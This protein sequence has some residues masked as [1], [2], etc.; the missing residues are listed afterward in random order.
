MVDIGADN[1]DGLTTPHA[2]GKFQIVRELGRGAMGIVYEAF[3]EDLQRRVALKIIAPSVLSSDAQASRRFADEARMAAGVHHP[4]IVTVHETGVVAGTAFLAMEFIEGGSLAASSGE[5]MPAH[6]AARIVLDVSRAVAAMHVRGV[7]HR[8]LKPDNIL[9]DSDGHPRVTDFGLAL[10]RSDQGHEAAGTPGFMA[11]E[12]LSSEFGPVSE[13]SDIY[14][15]GAVLHLLVAGVLPHE[16][17]TVIQLAMATIERDLPAALPNMPAELSAICRRCLERVQAHRYAS[18]TA[19]ADDL[20][21]WLR[22]DAT[23]ATP[24]GSWRRIRSFFRQRRVLAARLVA[25][26]IFEALTIVNYMFLGTPAAYFYDIQILLASLLLASAVLDWANRSG[27]RPRA[28]SYIWPLLDCAGIT[29]LL[30][31]GDGPSSSLTLLYPLLIVS[32]GLWFE[33]SAVVAAT[34]MAA[35]AYGILIAGSSLDVG[36]TTTVQHFTMFTTLLVTGLLVWLQVFRAQA[37]RDFASRSSG[38]RS[39]RP[40]LGRDPASGLD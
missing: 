5:R 21:C 36:V 38:F 13:K 3:Q 32:T 24:P 31:V 10:I 19:L 17:A 12:Q 40:Q 7:V 6:E 8:D 4:G 25:L 35:L 22:G 34:A 20:E 27:L 18:A 30:S 15:L 1:A 2:I 37:L 23:D 14:S 16:S 11:P 9:I 28:M 29:W 33:H 26:A 39:L